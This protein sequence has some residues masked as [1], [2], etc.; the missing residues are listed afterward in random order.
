MKKVYENSFVQGREL[1]KNIVIA[2][3]VGCA[4][5]LVTMFLG[6][7]GLQ[8]VLMA[9]TTVGLGAS[10]YVMVRYCVCPHCGKHITMGLLA[11]EHC[12]RCRRNLITGKK[13]KKK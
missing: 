6:Y 9:F 7:Q 5:S 1:T 12:P 4:L 3:V 13:G 2:T 11:I 8:F 10:I